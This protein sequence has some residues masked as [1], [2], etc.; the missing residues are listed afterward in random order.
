MAAASAE[1]ADDAGCG[2]TAST[3]S[4]WT[5]RCR[6]R[7]ASTWLRE[8]REQGYSGE[9]VL[10]TAFAD[11]DTAIEA[12]RAGARDFIL[13]PFRVHA[14]PQCGASTASSARS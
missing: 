2:A 12:L 11:L 9:V 6:A 13:K 5:S 4:S 7:A 1:E 3:W 10:I 8:L 14:D